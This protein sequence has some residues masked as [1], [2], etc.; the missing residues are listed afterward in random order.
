MRCVAHRK[1]AENLVEYVPVGGT[2]WAHPISIFACL[3][4]YF[5]LPV[6]MTESS[7][8]QAADPRVTGGAR[9]RH[10]RHFR[11]STR[12]AQTVHPDPAKGQARE[13]YVHLRF[14]RPERQRERAVIMHRLE[15][16]GAV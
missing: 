4:R 12:A 15:Q 6:D 8:W 2:K 13:Y 9:S 1:E 7:F 14:F 3:R 16:C 10:L 5:R 11:H